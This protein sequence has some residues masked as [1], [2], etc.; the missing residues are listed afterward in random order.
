MEYTHLSHT[1]KPAQ[2]DGIVRDAGP[3]AEP[4]PEVM[5]S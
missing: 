3:P 1:T 4:S 5:P 2:I